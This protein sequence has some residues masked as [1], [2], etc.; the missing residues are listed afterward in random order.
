MKTEWT[1]ESLAA[2]DQAVMFAM[3]REDFDAKECQLYL[4]AAFA[5]DAGASHGRLARRLVEFG[6]MDDAGKI[7]M[8]NSAL[9]GLRP[10]IL[11][12]IANN[13]PEAVNAVRS[14][15]LDVCKAGLV[16][17]IAEEKSEAAV[18]M[19][20]ALGPSSD[21]A[22]RLS[23]A[24]REA[25]DLAKNNLDA[26]YTSPEEFERVRH[27]MATIG[28]HCERETIGASIPQGTKVSRAGRAL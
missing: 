1:P 11:G 5:R 28:A 12:S 21:A 25:L 4:K 20:K 3:A 24:L 8:A 23:A 7:E 9:F 15:G 19:C 22:S 2:F 10:E 27:A 16:M 17:S 6:L 26:G 18:A 14:D 13:W